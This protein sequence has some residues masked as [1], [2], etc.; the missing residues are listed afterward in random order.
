MDKKIERLIETIEISENVA[1][2]TGAGISTL[3][4]IPDFRGGHNPLW[5]KFPQEK[6][7]DID[8]FKKD[9]VLFYD[10]LREILKKSY[11]SNI[12]HK[13]FKYLE[14]KGKL[15]GIITQNIDGLH[16]RA[17]SKAVYELHGSIYKSY[18]IKCKKKI[19]YDDFLKKINKE[20]VPL[21][22]CGGIIRPDVVFF[23]EVLPDY[24]LKMA[25]S[26]AQS[27]DLLLIA[28]T[29][30]VVQPAAYIPTLTLNSGGK[31]ILIN[32]GDTYIN[33]RASL[34][35]EEIKETFEAIAEYYMLDK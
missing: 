4:G 14:E 9:P 12:S 21:C 25:F 2:L 24:D 15:K 5:D 8:Y 28:G 29:S 30:L 33:D 6:V 31:V 34:V 27:S 1:A 13:V 3:S 23:G 17:G 11:E 26:L 7:F 20:K 16:Q 35:F 18:C 22:E 19:P 32:R 10:F